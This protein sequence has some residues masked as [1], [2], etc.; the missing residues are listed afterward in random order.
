MAKHMPTRRKI[1]NYG[2][3]YEP[4][5]GAIA[6]PKRRI[7]PF[8]LA[9]VVLAGII[10]VVAF[11]CSNAAA[12]AAKNNLPDTSGLSAQVNSNYGRVT[13]V[14]VGDNLPDDAIGG[15]ADSIKGEKGDHQ[16]DY[17]PVFANIKPLIEK[18][19]LAY[20]NQETHVGGNE[21]GAKGYPSFN[22]T[23]EMAQAVVDTGFDLVASATN[24]A[25]DWGTYGANEHSREVWNSLP[26]AFT[27]TARNAEEAAQ[28]PI[29]EKNGIKFSL[30]NYAGFINGFANDE[31]PSYTINLFD[32]ERMRNDVA[33][34]K[35][36]SD[37]VLCAM[38]WGTENY[39]SVDDEQKYY[40]KFLADLGVDVILGSHPHVIGP[41]GWVDGQNGH[42]T[43]VAYSLGNFLSRHETPAPINELEGMLSCTFSLGDYGVDIT[44]V[45]W[46]PLVN[47]TELDFFSIYTLDSYTNELGAKHTI[48]DSLDDPVG[49]LTAKNKE[50]VGIDFAT[51]FYE[52]P[53]TQ[54]NAKR[55]SRDAKLS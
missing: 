3:V 45:K 53:T 34:A 37:I 33:F 23:D 5:L 19:D 20:M 6:Q 31:L 41:V 17:T 18:A 14:A 42:K 10:L 48:L 15:Y 4:M 21:I 1:K 43:L 29:V 44:D 39:T 11:S 8:A 50:I 49:W 25:Y 24:H 40:A 36:N 30:L 52:P 51:Y 38:H 7:W 54:E 28:I 16:Y 12:N 22:T 47:H 35:A 46:T 13:F 2:S 26:V 27:G 55:I 32:E 9:L